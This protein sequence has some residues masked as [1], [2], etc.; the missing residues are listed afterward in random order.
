MED[1]T[2]AAVLKYKD[3]PSVLSIQSKYKNSKAFTFSEVSVKETVK[4]IRSLKANKASQNSNISPTIIKENNDIFA[5]FLR[6]SMNNSFKLTD[7]TLLHKK[8][9]KVLKN[10]GL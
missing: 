10:I 1:P 6:S 4:E 3:H 2:L 7:V 8:G 5:D 9:K